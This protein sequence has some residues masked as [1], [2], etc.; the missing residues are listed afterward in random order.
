MNR[1]KVWEYGE[2]AYYR[3]PRL[4]AYTGGEYGGSFPNNCIVRT[5]A[6]GFTIEWR[7]DPTYWEYRPASSEEMIEH[8][9]ARVKSGEADHWPWQYGEVPDPRISI[10]KM[11]RYGKPKPSGNKNGLTNAEYRGAIEERR[12]AVREGRY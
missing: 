10:E 5:L 8:L 4:Q 9:L 1:I 3:R 7:L 2:Y 12:K 11:D 6:D